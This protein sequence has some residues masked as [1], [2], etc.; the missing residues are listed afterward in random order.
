MKTN[1]GEVTLNVVELVILTKSLKVLPEKFH[2]LVNEEERSR[3]RYVDLIVNE[4]SLQTFA[5]R[6][7]I[8]SV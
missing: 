2:G 3:Q 6:S 7:R 1:T 4:Q 8:A 5:T